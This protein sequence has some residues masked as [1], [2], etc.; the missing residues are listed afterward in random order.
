M[1]RIIVFIIFGGF[2]VFMFVVG[3]R[4][5]VQQRRLLDAARPVEA[6]ILRSEVRS[7]R[8]SDTDSRTLR[9]NSTTSHTAD[10]LFR[11]EIDGRAYESDLL[12]PSVIVRGFASSEG[13]AEEVRPFP[14]GATVKAFVDPSRPDKAFLI[15]ER[16]AGPLV[17]M[18]I[19]LLLPPIAWFV[20]KLV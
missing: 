19:G 9:D 6:V 13:A 15:A 2:G 4:E 1:A 8:S 5:F 17:F 14:V 7:S 11:Y 12:R 18:I 3:V 10:V 20:G 16:S